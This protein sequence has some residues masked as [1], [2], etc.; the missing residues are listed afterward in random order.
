MGQAKIPFALLNLTS[1]SLAI[2]AASPSKQQPRRFACERCRSQNLHCER[3]GSS[4][5]ADAC[6]RCL[7]VAIS[8][9]E[10]IF[11][12]QPIFVVRATKQAGQS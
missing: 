6:R 10:E 5:T 11:E 1:M 4:N 2:P 7:R 3:L 9:G 8:T 12:R